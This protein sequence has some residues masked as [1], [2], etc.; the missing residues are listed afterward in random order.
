VDHEAK[1]LTPKKKDT[2]SSPARNVT[3]TTA[4]FSVEKQ[5]RLLYARGDAG[6]G[7]FSYTQGHS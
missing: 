4:H 2:V 7:R 3:H 1:V 6:D 5:W